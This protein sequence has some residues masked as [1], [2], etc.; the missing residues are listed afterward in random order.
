MLWIATL[1]SN[2]GTW[3]QEVASSWLMTT[4]APDPVMVSLVQVATALPVFLLGLPAGALADL[5]DKRRWLLGT[6]TWMMLSA[7]L[8]AAFTLGGGMTPWLLLVG[9]YLL[10][11]GAA[12]N[13]PGWHS[14]TPEIVPKSSLQTAVTL[15]GVIINCARALGPALG[16]LVVVQMGPGAAFVLNGISFLAVVFALSRWKRKAKNE[17]LPS[18]RFLSA[19]RVGVQHVCHSPIM[20]HLIVR[21]GVLVFSTSVAWALLPLLARQEYGF[22]P[23]GYGLLLVANALGAIL[24]ATVILPRVRENWDANQIVS[25]AWLG[26]IPTLIVL[27]EATHPVVPFLALLWG[28]VCNILMLSCFHL[29]AQSIAPDWV[30]SRAMA[31]YLLTFSGATTVGSIFWGFVARGI[32]LRHALLAGACFLLLGTVTKRVAPTRTGEE[33]DHE[34]CDYWPDPEL[35]MEVPLTHGPI[36]VMVDYEIEPEDSQEF[37]DAMERVRRIRYRNGVM[38]WGVYVD[39]ENPR[40]Y[41]EVYLEEN[42]AA[43]LRQH[44]RVSFY[45]MEVQAVLTCRFHRGDTAPQVRHL[46]YC[47]HGF[48]N[49]APEDA[50]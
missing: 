8:M 13:S 48:P 44:E 23:R 27:A 19:M 9:T 36:M 34:P 30:R 38:R 37:L 7:A 1:V 18:E 46:G 28:G 41:H 29:G 17:N 45:E 40:I 11:I 6:Q 20:R 39:I 31:V 33:F 50:E 25:Y 47:D 12:L 14:V 35:E 42:W 21:A 4:L 2:C 15:N 10:S 26:F 43:H 16:G 32:G 24:G 3:M 5:V 49:R 22:G